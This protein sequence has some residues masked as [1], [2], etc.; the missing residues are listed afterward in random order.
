[1][2]GTIPADLT[3]FF[4]HSMILAQELAYLYGHENLWLDEHNEWK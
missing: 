2:A 4:G 3:Q 1:M